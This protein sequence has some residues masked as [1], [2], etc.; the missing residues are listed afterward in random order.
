VHGREGGGFYAVAP[1]GG[2]PV[3][4]VQATYVGESRTGKP[5]VRWAAQH[6]DGTVTTHR[7]RKLATD[8]VKRHAG[9]RGSDED[10]GCG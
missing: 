3:G 9:L 6:A 1:A 2:L 4:L 7:S 10:C 8:A 5:K